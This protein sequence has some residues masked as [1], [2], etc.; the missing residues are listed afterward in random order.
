MTAQAA[1]SSRYAQCYG[2]EG[3]GTPQLANKVLRRWT[4]AKKRQGKNMVRPVGAYR[5]PHCGLFHLGGVGPR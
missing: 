4:T 5:C 3:F 1:N 2:K